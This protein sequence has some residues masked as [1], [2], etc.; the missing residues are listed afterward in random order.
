MAYASRSGRAR[1]NAKKPSA[2][3]VCDRCGIWTNLVS[4]KFQYDWRGATLQNLR[5][6]VCDRCYDTPQEQLR[7][8]VLPADPEPK[9]NAR[10]EQ[11][12][13]DESDY[14]AVS[15]IPRIDPNTGLPFPQNDLRITMDSQ[16]RVTEPYGAPVGDDQNAVMPYNGATQQA[17][18][19]PLALLSVTSDG[20]AT[21]TVTCS[22]VHGLQTNSQVSVEGLN[23]SP[24]CGIYTAVPTTATAFSYMT[25]GA[26]PNGS[27]L[28]S[29]T[30]ILTALMGL[31]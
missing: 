31:P 8:I 24:A 29:T 18:A 6:L 2:F 30:L 4:L 15:K 16:N 27:L 22:A 25:Y 10:V 20:S 23:W 11:F 17:F 5:L 21:V 12:A 14:R 1:T 19:I 9:M 3:A 13:Q 28:T 7:A 26:N